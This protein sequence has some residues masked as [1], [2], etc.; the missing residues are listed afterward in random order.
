MDQA[1]GV[2]FAKD[3]KSKKSSDGTQANDLIYYE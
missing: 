2:E 3:T 1:I